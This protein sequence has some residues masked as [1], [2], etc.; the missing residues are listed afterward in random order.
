M[1]RLR[2]CLPPLLFVLVIAGLALAE[3]RAAV[4]NIETIV[5]RM[6]QAR[7]S[8]QALLRAYSV[9]RN[10]TLLGEDPVPECVTGA[11]PLQIR[12]FYVDQACSFATAA[13]SRWTTR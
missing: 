5:Q 6:A 13:S 1:T 10:Y 8:N 12:R 4:P 3:D 11:A 7:E 2:Q 9:T